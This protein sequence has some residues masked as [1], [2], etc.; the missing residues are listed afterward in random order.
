MIRKIIYTLF[1]LCFLLFLTFW[2]IKL[3]GDPKPSS[4]TEEYLKLHGY[5]DGQVNEIRVGGVLL[6]FPAG[7]KYSPETVKNIVKGKADAV[8][9]GFTFPIE[10]MQSSHLDIVNV[11]FR[12]YIGG[13][14]EFWEN[15]IEKKKWEKITELDDL[16][17]VE[18]IEAAPYGGWGETSYVSKFESLDNE[19]AG[20]IYACTESGEKIS[21]C[22]T[23]FPWKNK[24]FIDVYFSGKN[25][26]NW[27][28]INREV[29]KFVNSIIIEE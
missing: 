29:I 13:T 21:R 12:P 11:E 9:S 14:Y 3:T 4:G 10:A 1:I 28:S 22:W 15:Q 26:K 18:Y 6:R 5:V 2:V 17:L 23:R 27:R 24:V 19:G 7:M 16:G 25:L 8:V 20:V